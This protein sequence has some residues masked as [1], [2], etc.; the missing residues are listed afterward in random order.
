MVRR[1]YGHEKCTALMLGAA[2][3]VRTGFQHFVISLI[4]EPLEVLHEEFAKLLDLT[5]EIG[6][7][8]PRLGRVEQL[9]GNVG[10]SLGHGKI[11][12]LVSLVLGLCELAGVNGVEDGASV[13]EGAS[14]SY[15]KI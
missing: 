1:K 15:T 12:G 5:L 6:G 13:L 14:L 8:I 11:E 2:A 3:Y 10:A 7:T 4:L 9:V